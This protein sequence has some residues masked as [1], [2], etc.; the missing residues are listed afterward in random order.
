MF[1]LLHQVSKDKNVSLI[2]SLSYICAPYLLTDIYIRGSYSE[3]FTF[4]FVPLV[5]LGLHELFHNQF[6]NF[7]LY[8]TMGYVGMI[9]SHLVI[10]VYLTIF[11]CILFL[12][13]IKKVVKWD[14][15]K[16]LIIASMIV[17]L[18]TSP[19]W[20]PLLEHK[21][22]GNYVVF[23]EDAMSSV[24][25]L[26]ESSLY[27]RDFFITNPN[28]RSNINHPYLNFGTILL[29]FI[30]IYYSKRIFDNKKMYLSMLVL[31]VISIFM[32]TVYFPWSVVPKF[33]QTIQFPWRLEIF[34]VFRMSFIGAYSIK[35]WK[36][37][38][39]KIATILFS[40]LIIWMGFDSIYV[41][42]VASPVDYETPYN[43]AMGSQSEYLPVKTKKE[44]EYLLERDKKIH[45]VKGKAEINEVISDTPYLKANIEMENS[46]Q[47][48]ILQLPRIYY[49]G[50]S[51]TLTTDDQIEKIDYYE[52]EHGFIEIHLNKSGILEMKY[53]GTIM[54]QI[55]K[56]V[57]FVTLLFSIAWFYR[58]FILRNNSG[59]C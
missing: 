2:G 51:I 13:N 6:K 41:N 7:Y 43:L 25:D 3:L 35:I 12:I 11:I 28:I 16:H 10:T 21:I 18:L 22:F 56:I 52:D 53:E 50:Y 42:T 4:I 14:Y 30:G 49:F 20:I 8:F 17:L 58:N 55:S 9:L 40:I 26:K 5:F 57:C 46:D 37:E 27:F 15:I 36:S 44:K 1:L 47:K 39:K 19:F 54:N 45:V 24:A 23:Q 29:F 38:Q 59:T 48:V 32:T 31:T 33:L 34:I